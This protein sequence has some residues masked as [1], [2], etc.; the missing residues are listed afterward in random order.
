[1]N[2][3]YNALTIAGSTKNSKFLRYHATNAKKLTEFAIL[4]FSTTANIKN[5]KTTDSLSNVV[6]AK[7]LNRQKIKIN[8]KL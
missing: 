6:K 4:Q 3:W 2:F 1:M 7:A 8:A 5:K